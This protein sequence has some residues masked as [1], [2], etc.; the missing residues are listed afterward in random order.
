MILRRRR[1]AVLAAAVLLPAALAAA[2]AGPVPVAV[3]A[4]GGAAPVGAAPAPSASAP[5]PQGATG[6]AT[7]GAGTTGGAVAGPALARATANGITIETRPAAL[8]KRPARV[9]GSAP[10]RVGQVR[11]EQLAADGAWSVVA[12]VAVAGDGTYAAAWRPRALGAQ[13]LRVV[14]ATDAAPAAEAPPQVA[15]TVLRPGVASWYGPGFYGGRTAC[16]VR[17]RRTTLGVAHKTLP[18]GTQVQFQYG[19][20]SLVVP[21]IDRGPFVTGR[22]WDLTKHTHTVLGARDGL[23]TVGALPQLGV[24]RL[25]TPYQAPAIRSR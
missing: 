19:T 24:P 22:S 5:A 3:A 17:L 13:Q 6:R 14:A 20:R 23:I 10:A 12:T 1:T 4:T 21:V 16:G 25:A 8:L 15:V 9:S 18:C 11:L 7:T 2:P